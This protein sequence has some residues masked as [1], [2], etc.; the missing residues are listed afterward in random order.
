[1]SLAWLE[2]PLRYKAAMTS[3]SCVSPEKLITHELE[4]VFLTCELVFHSFI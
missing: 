3:P 4:P 2:D 1:V